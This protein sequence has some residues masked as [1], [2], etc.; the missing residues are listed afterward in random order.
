MKTVIFC[1]YTFLFTTIISAQV[2]ESG[3]N[4]DAVLKINS[5]VNSNNKISFDNSLL[6]GKRTVSY[7]NGLYGKLYSIENTDNNLINIGSS[8][9]DLNGDGIDDIVL[10]TSTVNSS[11]LASPLSIL[12][13]KGDDGEILFKSRLADSSNPEHTNVLTTDLNGDG[14]HEVFVLYTSEG[15]VKYIVYDEAGIILS[16]GIILNHNIYGSFYN[17]ECL[18]AD[19]NSDQCDDIFVSLQFRSDKEQSTFPLFFIMDGKKMQV[20]ELSVPGLSNNQVSSLFCTT[21]RFSDPANDDIL[22]V[23]DNNTLSS[24]TAASGI[25][26]INGITQ[27]TTNYKVKDILPQFGNY[28]PWLI[29]KGEINN[30]GNDELIISFRTGNDFNNDGIPDQSTLVAYSFHIGRKLFIHTPQSQYNHFYSTKILAG[31]YNN[32]GLDEIYHMY[33]AFEDITG[34]NIGDGSEIEYLDHNGNK[35]ETFNKITL[36]LNETDRTD[37]ILDFQTARVSNNTIP[38]LILLYRYGTDINNDNQ[39]DGNLNVFVNTSQNSV[40]YSEHTGNNNSD[41]FATNK[42]LVIENEITDQEFL[43]MLDLDKYNLTSVKQDFINRDYYSALQ[44][45]YNYYLNDRLT[46][47][48]YEY[49]DYYLINGHDEFISR[50]EKFSTTVVKE[51]PAFDGIS[52]LYDDPSAGA[53]RLKRIAKT[54]AKRCYIDKDIDFD[55]LIYGLKMIISSARWLTRDENF[56]YGYNHGMIF[57]LKEN[58]LASAH[59]Y[60]TKQFDKSDRYSFQTFFENRFLNQMSHI[61]PDGLHDEHSITYGFLIAD[62]LSIAIRYFKENPF[63]NIDPAVLD[64][65]K[66]NA[67]NMYTYF[68]HAVKPLATSNNP[69]TVEFRPDITVIG[70]SDSRIVQRW[71]GKESYSGNPSVLSEP[72]TTGKAEHW[73]NT[74]LV[75]NLN[76]AAYPHKNNQ[77]IPPSATSKA[78]PRAGFM[79]SRSNWVIP[80]SSN[81][82]DFNARY[83]HFKAGELAPTPGP[84]NGHTTSSTH[85]HGDLLSLDLVAYNKNLVVDPG[86]YVGEGMTTVL[87][88]FN[89][90]YYTSLYDQPAPQGIFNTVR[91]YF[92]CTGGH[93]TVNVNGGQVTYLSNWSYINYNSLNA[94]PFSYFI[95]NEIDYAS[96]GFEKN[97]THGFYT[98]T[99]KVIYNKPLFE[100]SVKADYWIIIDLLDFTNYTGNITANQNWHISPEQTIQSINSSGEFTGENLKILPLKSDE[101]PVIPSMIPGYTMNNL[102]LAESNVVKY[103]A[104]VN[105]NKF[106]YTTVIIPFDNNKPISGEELSSISISDINGSP[107]TSYDVTGIKVKFITSDNK[108]LEDY[109]TVS[110]D[111]TR[112]FMWQPEFSDTTIISNQMI[113]TYRFIDGELQNKTSLKFDTINGVNTTDDFPESFNLEQNYPNPFNGTTKLTFQ[114]K[115]P[116]NYKL[117]IYDI[118]GKEIATVVDTE[119]QEGIYKFIWNGKNERGDTMA[120]GIYLYRLSN[121]NLSHVKKMIYLK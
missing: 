102:T 108:L 90:E 59:I 39:K 80:G 31:D 86:G 69:D 68:L 82:Y 75:E 118:L 84:Y 29:T 62:E 74:T 83:M 28:H 2:F 105:S 49:G 8:T 110:H 11:T 50:I 12:T 54:L 13:F 53:M 96:G 33:K 64:T 106:L 88:N 18:T 79:V 66:K 51:Y 42:L 40:F 113:E 92:K 21:G 109:I 101:F 24:S 45:Y 36:G 1:I 117:K 57:E 114:V 121:G 72:L 30:Q 26:L 120:S 3:F 5:T 47:V 91:A 63:Y 77:G 15:K 119:L 22:I 6:V 25:F 34:D 98:H 116:G 60:E 107:L 112:Q 9:G 55:V 23:T 94:T 85:G 97:D 48:H 76:F 38:D 46:P 81:E 65:L 103:K 67:E 58:F 32:D 111:S 99:R 56:Y 104:I 16:E 95:G 73:N 4:S 70:D 41:M 93:N 14:K 52:Y 89:P 43:R 87:N 78:F 61:L 71:L 20:S 10:L 7:D 35:I 44:K 17:T 100:G 27:E 19:F 115:D 37:E